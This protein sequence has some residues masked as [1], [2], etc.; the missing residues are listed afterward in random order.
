MNAMLNVKP[1]NGT[2]RSMDPKKID[3]EDYSRARQWI[4]NYVGGHKDVESVYEYGSVSSPGLSDLDLIF[5]LN[6]Y[7]DKNVSNF[8]NIS[9]FPK[10]VQTILEYSSLIILPRK[11]IEYL[12][13]WDDLN[14]THLY[15]ETYDF[16]LPKGL[17]LDAI[18]LCRIIDWLP[19][20]ILRF[21][22]INNQTNSIF[23][24]KCLGVL[25]TLIYSLQ[26]LEQHFDLNQSDWK[27]FTKAV[28]ELRADW[29]IIKD[30]PKR[31]KLLLKEGQG[32]A[33]SAWIQFCNHVKYKEAYQ[34][35]HGL[36][37]TRLVFPGGAFYAFSSNFDNESYSMKQ[38][39]LIS[40]PCPISLTLHFYFYAQRQGVISKA[41]GQALDC[42]ADNRDRVQIDQ[43][44]KKVLSKRMDLCNEWAS[45]LKENDFN[46]GLFKF[47]W[48]FR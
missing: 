18:H 39:N 34:L 32:I 37:D 5:V 27:I 7:P 24:R 46:V 19:E 12:L 21:K 45:F 31:L 28:E 47:G 38:N 20:R 23:N 14:L 48:F 30:G 6:D 16:I 8:L 44:L 35:K 1:N 13:W 43:N 41:L 11:N 9:Q 2:N 36:E 10:Y 25:K 29:F 15:G 33:L 22:E 17:D 4:I 40:A 42:H 26:A 3:I